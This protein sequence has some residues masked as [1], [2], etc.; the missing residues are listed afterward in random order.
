MFTIGTH[1]SLMDNTRALHFALLGARVT[2]DGQS[3]LTPQPAVAAPRVLLRAMY[4]A[5]C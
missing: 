3:T 2:E 5:A 4:W 1:W